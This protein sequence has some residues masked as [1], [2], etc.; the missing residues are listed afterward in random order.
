MNYRDRIT[1]ERALVRELADPVDVLRD[2]IA[3]VTGLDAAFVFGSE[4]R[5]DAR[6]DSDIDVFILESDDLSEDELSRRTLDAGVL[7]GREIN[8]VAMS[9]DKLASRVSEGRGFLS[10]V[11][12]NPKRW[13]VGDATALRGVRRAR[14]HT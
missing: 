2:A 1:I 5:G 14:T 9:R 7:L 12:D 4:A 10:G 6:P 3:D 13:I 8:V 11:L